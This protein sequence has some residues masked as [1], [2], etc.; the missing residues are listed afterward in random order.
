MTIYLFLKTLKDSFDELLFLNSV[1]FDISHS[2]NFNYFFWER[3]FFQIITSP[4]FLFILLFLAF[5]GFYMYY[6][7]KKIGK[8]SGW[9]VNI[10]LFYALF[11]VLFGF[12]WT[13]SIIYALFAKSV[14]W[15]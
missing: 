12:W 3:L 7:S 6:A 10:Y 9:L 2:F 8:I 4:I 11:A 13:V 1:N 14:K 5:S 15:R